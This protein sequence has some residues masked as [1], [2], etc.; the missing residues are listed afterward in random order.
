MWVQISFSLEVLDALDLE[1]GEVV[2]SLVWVLGI[3]LWSS[4]RAASIPDH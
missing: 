4:G 2:C 3:E 1:L